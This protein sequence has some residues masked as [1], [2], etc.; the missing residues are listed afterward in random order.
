MAC[1]PEGKDNGGSPKMLSGRQ[2]VRSVYALF[3][4]NHCVTGASPVEGLK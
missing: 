4:Y 1:G 2:V 3:Y